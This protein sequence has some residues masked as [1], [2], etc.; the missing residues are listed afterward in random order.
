MKTAILGTGSWGTA[1]GQVLTDNGHAVMMYGV[2]DGEITDINIRHRNAKYFGDSVLLPDSL[3]ATHDMAEA[4]CGADAVVL[5]VP[6]R[7]IDDVLKDLAPLIGKNTIIINASKGFDLKANRRISETIRDILGEQLKRPVVSIIGPSHAE[8]VILRQL[9][10]ICSVSLD[11][12]TARSVQ[13]AFSNSY[14]RLYVNTDEVG[15]EYGVAIKNIIA[16]AS[17]ILVGQGYGD[18]A[19]A[20]LVTRGLAEM[21]RYGCAKGGKPETYTGLTGVGDLVVTCFS[22]HSRNYQA[23]LEIGRLDSAAEFLAHNTKTVEGI[24]S[25]RAVYEDLKNYDFEMPIVSALY[26]VLYEGEKPS[27]AIRSLMGRPLKHE[28]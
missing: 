4:V 19:K 25:C 28:I 9:T 3:C 12:D 6:T 21:I 16:I 26:R 5:A 17:G 23:G 2:D 15:S 14:L 18:N 1:L 20:A 13:E 24:Y 8:E 22:I 7:F 10:S 27:E 11:A